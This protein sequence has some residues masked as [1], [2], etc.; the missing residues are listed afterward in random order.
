MTTHPDDSA[1]PDPEDPLTVILRPPDDLLGPPVGRYREIRRT[2]G[3]RKA[4]RALTTAGVTCAVAVLVALPL[5]TSGPGTPDA[6]V[7]PMAPP[8]VSGST[9]PTPSPASPAPE[10]RSEPRDTTGSPVAS[11]PSRRAEKEPRTSVPRRE[12][13]EATLPS[14]IASVAPTRPVQDTP[15]TPSP[16][17]ELRTSG[18]SS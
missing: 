1:G 8:P 3:R 4:L 11:P 12:A 14:S 15:T 13:S 6:P 2:A 9:V 17:R 5:R 16:S 18:R 10:R 7:V